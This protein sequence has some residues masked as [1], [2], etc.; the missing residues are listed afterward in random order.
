MAQQTTNVESMDKEV[1][2]DQLNKIASA[3]RERDELTVRVGNKDITLTPPK[4][5]NY[6]IDV[7]EKNRWFRGDRETIRIELDWKPK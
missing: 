2:A 3:L 7:T 4:N 6:R 1:V 5:V